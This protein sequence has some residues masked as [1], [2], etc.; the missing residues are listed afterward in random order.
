MYVTNLDEV[1]P[2]L[3]GKLREYLGTK[4]G[5]RA[6][7]RKFKCFAHD[8]S[9]PSMC[10]NPKTHDETVKC[11]SC[12]WTGDIFA[13]AAVLD[14]LPEAGSEWI[15]E[16]IP[17]LCTLL[18]IPIRLG[19]PTPADKEKARIYKLAQD[20][21]DILSGENAEENP[22]IKDRNWNQDYLQIGTI[23][24]DILISKL[25]ERGWDAN[26]I[27]RS[28]L[29]RTKYHSFFGE[30]KV[31][32]V[33]RD[34]TG[35]PIGFISRDTAG[36]ENK[37]INS[38]ESLVYEKSKVLLG[39]DVATQE[40]KK[41]GLYIVEGPGDLAQ[42]YRV[43]IKNAVS[44]CGTA[45]TEHHLLLLKSLG[46]RKLFFCFD[47]DHAGYI[48][49]QR[50]LENVL[51]TTVGFST[52][53]VLPPEGETEVE[54]PDDLLSGVNEAT[55]FL[56][57]Q[58]QSAFEWQLQQASDNDT[59]DTICARMV[60][61]IAAEPAAVKRELL[62]RTLV[63]FTGVSEQAI[64]SDISSL[65]NNKFTERKE[66][67][68]ASAEKYMQEALEDPNNIMAAIAQHEQSV[69]RIEKEY[70]RNI[71][72][73]NY[74][75]ARYEAIQEQR[76][77]DQVDGSRAT[78][79]MNY[80]SMF[81]EAMAGGMNWVDGCLM[82][83]GGRAN[84]GKT[85][86]VLGLACDVALS[87]EDSMV[88]IHSTDDS[89]PQIEPRIKA[90]LYA[91]ANPTGPKLTIG[92][93]VQPHLYLKD[94]PEKYKKAYAEADT[95]IKDLLNQERIIILDAEDGATLSVLEKNI[96]Y[97]R[98]RYPSKKLLLVSDNTHN[99]MDWAHMDQTSRLTQISNMQKTLVTKYHA[100]ML[101]TAEYRKNMPMDHSKLRLPVDDDLADARSLMYRPNI[102]FHVYNDLHDRKE[103]AE[104]FW[105]GSDGKTNPRLLLHFTKNKISGY[106]DKLIIDLD[107]ETVSLRP[108]APSVALEEAETFRDMKE[109]G[110]ARIEGT[111]IVYTNA[112]E[113]E[114]NAS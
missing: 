3:R 91:M 99:Y 68:V 16:T 45:F 58:L 13:A 33:I 27:A 29:V 89:Y 87:D 1:L 88:I 90:N 22:Y 25:A 69:S 4:L 111:S 77:I 39:I 52:F 57:L 54:D 14:N 100:C 50:V 92:M 32:F 41:E 19:E 84:S 75:L 102:I 6:N 51:K 20:I 8:D 49:T 85:A 114:A 67:L 98:Q 18:E 47:W 70:Q 106:K 66:R 95:L 60:P 43:G 40:A 82:Y 62:T 53:I 71:V 10:F 93:I 80:F 109:R 17:S 28:F 2:L 79:H 56:E 64:S 7:A 86:V 55:T 42:L 23:D 107:P 11:F 26:D 24:E 9:D 73:V 21:A 103:H 15:T 31:T 34:H 36:A 101:A 38:P 113:Y 12:G 61:L 78:F 59:P 76:S 72:G 108:R 44:I 63:Q 96:R 112:T 48:A 110:E 30:D 81:E 104:I 83:V 37:Y 94:K 65:R 97:Y 35:K 74:Q 46:V 5:I 105:R